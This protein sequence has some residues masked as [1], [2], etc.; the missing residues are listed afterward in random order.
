MS[1]R[2]RTV[3]TTPAAVLAG[4]VLAL[5]PAAP[6]SAA[7]WSVVSTPNAGPGRNQLSGVD[8]LS[9]TDAWAVGSADASTAP[10]TRPLA[11][12]WDGTGWTLASPPTPAAGGQLN[13]VDGSA[14]D[15]VWAVGTAA[16][17][18]L[19]LTQHWNGTSWATAPS[20]S[21]AGATTVNLRDVKTFGPG[22][23]WAVGRVDLA[24]PASPRG[25]T[26]IQ[27]WNGTS[28]NIVPSPNPDAASNQLTAVDGV[29]ADDVWAVGGFGEDGYGRATVV[30][31]VVHWNGSAW[32]R[33]PLPDD[34]PML[35]VPELRDVV[36]VATNDVWV[37]GVVFHFGVFQQVPYLLHWNGSTWQ[38]G[39]ITNPAGTF[40][41]VTALSPTQVYAVGQA[42]GGQTLVA[43][44]N[45]STWTRE[46]TPSPGTS[47]LLGAAA[48]GTGTVWAVGHQIPS[49]GASRT[50]AI[51]AG[52][53]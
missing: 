3:A 10:W 8:A 44:W 12:H 31:L 11:V 26:L 46:A 18:T 48:T 27:R 42:S 19:P 17:W 16:S 9:G 5:A 25:Q 14:S 49:G 29:A 45:G 15:N 32:T 28:W 6:A 21:P 4:A 23:A 1:N 37:V 24:H 52:D 13:A 43:R 39:A 22:D 33:V 50:L 53:G 7:T 2:F 34:G 30:P 40:N 20:P 35:A 36:A 38:H 41:G 51:G 47:A